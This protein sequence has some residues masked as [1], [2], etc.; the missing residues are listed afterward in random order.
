MSNKTEKKRDHV[1]SLASL[2]KVTLV[3][4]GICALGKNTTTPIEGYFS[5]EQIG[6][7]PYEYRQPAHATNCSRSSH[8]FFGIVSP[9]LPL[10]ASAPLLVC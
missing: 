9:D 4:E 5:N 1:V 3:K 8:Q 10:D 6:V 7:L 2:S